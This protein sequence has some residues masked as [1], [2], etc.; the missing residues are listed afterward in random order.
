MQDFYN[1]AENVFEH[2]A[3]SIDEAVPT[4]ADW[5]R[6]LLVQMRT[7]LAT[8]RPSVLRRDTAAIL[9]EFLAFRHVFRNVYGY[10]LDPERLHR[11][12]RRFPAASSA[13][14]EDLLY[15]ART[16]AETVPEE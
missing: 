8:R 1:A 7:A 11:L 3:R 15:F 12:V 9:E 4:G 2:I 5:H 13:L 16:M 6:S 10:A 14:A